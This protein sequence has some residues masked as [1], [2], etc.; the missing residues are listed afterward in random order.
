MRTIEI[1]LINQRNNLKPIHSEI[2]TLNNNLCSRKPGP[3]SNTYQINSNLDWFSYNLQHKWAYDVYRNLN[4]IHS[5]NTSYPTSKIQR[6][7]Y[8]ILPYFNLSHFLGW[9]IDPF[10]INTHTTNTPTLT[11]FQL[12][13]ARYSTDTPQLS[14]SKE[15]HPLPRTHFKINHF[16]SHWTTIT[17]ELWPALF[18]L[19][20]ILNSVISLETRNWLCSVH[21]LLLSYSKI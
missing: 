10:S 5:H 9:M 19:L 14:Q 21:R 12:N 6:R 11:S 13:I 8:I 1:F 17:T 20:P 16:L 4:K 2:K 15:Q 18:S 3:S 7:P